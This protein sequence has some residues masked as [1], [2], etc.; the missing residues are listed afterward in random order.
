[1]SVQ[2]RLILL[3]HAQAEPQPLG[4]AD[5]AR[6]LTHRGR[7]DAGAVGASLARAGWL[8]DRVLCSGAVR[9]RETWASLEER[10]PHAPAAVFV[11]ALYGGAPEV[12]RDALV[13]H[14][15]HDATVLAIGHNPL[16]EELATWMSGARVRL[17]PGEAACLVAGAADWDAMWR[18]HSATLAAVIGA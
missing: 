17:R 5:R 8:P 16:W 6:P 12:V 18:A 3:R 11:D 4:G 7:R 2:R 13:Q 14:A 1:M 9:A 10:F 15:P